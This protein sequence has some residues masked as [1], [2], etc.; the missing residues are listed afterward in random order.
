[1]ACLVPHIHLYVTSYL[2][3]KQ[4]RINRTHHNPSDKEMMDGGCF[5]AISNLKTNVIS[6]LGTF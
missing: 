6:K 2:L 3:V 1:M 5:T 4:T